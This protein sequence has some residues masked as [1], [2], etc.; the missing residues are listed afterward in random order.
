MQLLSFWFCINICE[1]LTCVTVGYILLMR[2]L[3]KIQND[4]LMVSYFSNLKNHW[5]LF[6][7]L[8]YIYIDSS[9][10]IYFLASKIFLCLFK[11]RTIMK[12]NKIIP[13]FK[14]IWI[15]LFFFLFSSWSKEKWKESNFFSKI[16]SR[17]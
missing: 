4:P 13:H 17:R 8:F 9:K 6:F 3:F 15:H 7:F 10:V 1:N 16:T 5:L 11:G 12:N 2:K 14:K